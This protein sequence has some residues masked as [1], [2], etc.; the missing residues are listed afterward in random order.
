[1]RGGVPD[2][3]TP[4]AGSFPRDTRSFLEPQAARFSRFSVFF[5]DLFGTGARLGPDFG[6]L[7]LQ[8]LILIASGLVLERA[9]APK[10]LKEH[11]FPLVFNVFCISTF[12]LMLALVPHFS[13][14]LAPFGTALCSILSPS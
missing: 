5:R 1:M 8:T 7:S 6:P 12:S 2:V 3:L 11:Y 10:I 13:S 4:L 9:R 14:V